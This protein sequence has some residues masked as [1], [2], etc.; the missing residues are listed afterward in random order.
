MNCYQLGILLLNLLVQKKK[1]IINDYDY[2]IF[3]K[4]VE[5]LLSMILNF[6]VINEKVYIFEP[7]IDYNIEKYKFFINS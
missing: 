2:L 4:I 1:K 5:L 7:N 6:I 3:L